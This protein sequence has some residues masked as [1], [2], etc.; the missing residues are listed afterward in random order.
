MSLVQRSALFE[1][2]RQLA[3]EN[4]VAPSHKA[5]NYAFRNKSSKLTQVPNITNELA[6]LNSTMV[7]V[8][9]ML[10]RVDETVT[11]MCEKFQN[12]VSTLRP[13]FDETKA[14]MVRTAQTTSLTKVKDSI[15]KTTNAISLLM[16]D[17]CEQG[18]AVLANV[19]PALQILVDEVF[20]GFVVAA[21]AAQDMN[22]QAKCRKKDA[23]TGK[24]KKPRRRFKDGEKKK[25]ADPK[26]SLLG[27]LLATSLERHSFDHL[28]PG[29]GDLDWTVSN[30]GESSVDAPCKLVE[31]V[32]SE[33]LKTNKS[34]VKL[35]DQVAVANETCHTQVEAV[36]DAVQE[37][38]EL[39]N[40]TA[41]E[42]LANTDVDVYIHAVQTSLETVSAILP[43]EMMPLAVA[44]ADEV[45]SAI[46]TVQATISAAYEFTDVFLEEL[47]STC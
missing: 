6:F 13:L 14:P 45:N 9:H 29:V 22:D 40:T 28:L 11:E 30:K 23:G 15:N 3:P 37:N 19:L 26:E 27:G 12:A 5:K 31:T 35:L 41:F 42:A 8:S 20:S 10:S 24:K 43:D 16:Q 38:F 17:T 4:A 47:N 7:D 1:I 21:M 36:V 39:L 18:Y 32:T 33:V 25:H 44:A 2:D 46:E 34:V